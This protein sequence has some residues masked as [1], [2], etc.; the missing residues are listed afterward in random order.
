MK[1]ESPGSK[2][3]LISAKTQPTLLLLELKNA[4]A[5]FTSMYETPTNG[6]KSS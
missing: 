5:K 3:T 2:Q 6:L 4:K 1:K